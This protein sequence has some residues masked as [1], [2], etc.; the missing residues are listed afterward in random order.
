MKRIIVIMHFHN[1]FL[2]F[3]H[4]SAVFNMIH[5]AFLRKLP[6]FAFRESERKREN[7]RG[8]IDIISPGMKDI[9]LTSFFSV[10]FCSHQLHYSLTLQCHC[11]DGYKETPNL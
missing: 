11:G 2:L 5:E 10:Y 6:L 9:Y 3:Y 4:H 1:L 8:I 7:E